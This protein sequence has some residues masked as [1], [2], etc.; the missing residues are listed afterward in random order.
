MA[1]GVDMFDCVHPTRVARRGALFTP[2]GRVNVTAARFRHEFGPIDTN[3]DCSTCLTYSVAYLHHLF[4]TKELLA[5]RLA[6]IHNLRFIQ[7]LMESI[8]QSIV[9]GTFSAEMHAFLERYTVADLEAAR[10]QKQKWADA[11]GRSGS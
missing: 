5:Y 6:T 9:D 10:E 1:L 7:R 8:R 11:R 4:R 3:C 2:D